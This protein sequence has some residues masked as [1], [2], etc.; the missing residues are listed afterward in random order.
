MDDLFKAIYSKFTGSTGATS[1][2]VTLTG[3]LHNTKAP[4]D[5]NYPYAIFYLIGDRPD[6]T[7]DSLMEN[8]LIQFTIYDDNSGVS[9]IC[10]LFKALKVLYDNAVLSLTDYDSIAVRREFS[11]L[12]T[13]FDI[14]QYV[15]QY[16][17][18][19]QEK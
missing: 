17:I 18:I 7:F 13:S 11:N 10:D 9:N 4:Q 16:R 15:C 12:E 19:I 2:Y 5:T 1:L 8:N 6:R 14:W 3:G